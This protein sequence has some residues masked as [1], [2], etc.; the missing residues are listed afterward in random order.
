MADDKLH[1]KN[2][3]G[4]PDPTVYSALKRVDAEESER[5]HKLLNTIFYICSIA[6]FEIEGRIVLRD[7]RSGRTWR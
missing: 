5:F 2:S 6:G 7:R 3:E 4:Y 1:F